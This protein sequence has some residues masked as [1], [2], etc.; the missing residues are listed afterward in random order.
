VDQHVEQLFMHCLVH[1]DVQGLKSLKKKCI[2]KCLIKFES[3]NIRYF[4]GRFYYLFSH[5]EEK[6]EIKIVTKKNNVYK[7]SVKKKD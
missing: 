5:D 2:K 6:E 4:Y 7:L 1:K 3:K